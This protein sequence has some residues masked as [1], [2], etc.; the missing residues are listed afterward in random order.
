MRKLFLTMSAIVAMATV[1]LAQ[2]GK[3]QVGVGAELN[4][5]TGTG[6]G[7]AFGGT[8]KYLHGVGTAGQVTLTTGALFHS[9]SYTDPD[10]GEV[11]G[12]LRYIPVL[13]GYRHN[14]NGLYVE[15]QLG[16][17]ASHASVKVSGQSYGSGSS[18]SFTYAVGGGY[19]FAN[20][21]DLGVHF[22]NTT[23]AG[24]S[25]MIAFRVGYNFSLSGSA[26]QSKKFR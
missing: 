14:F 16:Y 2:T 24:A 8:V 15:P 20:G 12:T 13:V 19:A 25:G 4:L 22:R 1:S 7:S 26:N 17:M 9:E 6:G 23:E 10:D 18:G 5:F 11:K 21:L 3:N